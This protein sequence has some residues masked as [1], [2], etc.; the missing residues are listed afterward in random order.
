MTGI[1]GILFRVYSLLLR[2]YPGS[3]RSEF[4][5]QMQLDFSDLA[6]DARKKGRLSFVLFCLQELNDFPISLWQAHSKRD[7]MTGVFRSGP[8]RGAFQG[9]VTLGSALVIM[10]SIVD[11]ILITMQE[12]GWQFLLRIANS[13]GWH[14]NYNLMAQTI[15][16]FSTL[17]IGALLAG[18]L[19]ALCLRETRRIKRYLVAGLLGWVAPLVL[20]RIIGLLLKINNESLRNTVLDYSWIILAG[21]GFGT[22]FSLILRDRKKTLWLLLA[23][24]FGYYIATNL[25]LWLLTPL[26]PTYTPGPFTW[27]DLAYIVSLY[28]IMGIVIG[29]L[30]GAISG[31]SRNKV[32]SE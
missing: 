3:F 24:V 9:A 18:T 21:L 16:Y 7:N 22:V 20:I 1:P 29:A 6:A 12:Q 14:L 8:V 31:W 11:W 28:G 13:R 19:L 10:M 4:Q 2:L 5:E 27:N 17:I 15:L 23:G 26:F 32:I 25:T 30:L